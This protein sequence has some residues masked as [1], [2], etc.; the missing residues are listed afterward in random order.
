[1]QKVVFVP[2]H[3]EPIYKERQVK[4]PTG[5][6]KKGWL[7]NEKEVTRTESRVELVGESDCKIDGK[8][9]ANDINEEIANLIKDGYSISTIQDITSGSY[10]Y[11]YQSMHLTSEPRLTGGTEAVSGEGA[12]GYGYGFGYTSGVLLLAEKQ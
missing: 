2:A 9:L 5:E 1:M 4:V 10:A 12:F 11:K 7:G 8:R 6:T 3:G